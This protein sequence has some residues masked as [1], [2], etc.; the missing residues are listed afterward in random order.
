MIPN[1]I[2]LIIC[3]YRQAQ[4]NPMRRLAYTLF[5]YSAIFFF[6]FSTRILLG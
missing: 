1:S 5:L 3:Q 2:Y 6:L 4:E